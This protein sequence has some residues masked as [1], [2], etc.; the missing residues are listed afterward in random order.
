MDSAF[1]QLVNPVNPS[2]EPWMLGFGGCSRL[3]IGYASHICDS[4]KQAAKAG[5]SKTA[6]DLPKNPR[7]TSPRSPGL[8]NP[9]NFAGASAAV[10]ARLKKGSILEASRGSIFEAV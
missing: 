9:A 8:R 7:L 4:S 3:R 10:P 5:A 1:P 2:S 6:P